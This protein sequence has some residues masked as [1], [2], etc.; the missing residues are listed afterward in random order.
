MSQDT[1]AIGSAILQLDRQLLKGGERIALGPRALAILSMLARHRGEIVSKDELFAEIWPDTTVEENALQ[2][3]VTA[4]RKALG[5]DADLL[6]TVRGIG[7]KLHLEAG[8]TA[9]RLRK[10]KLNRSQVERLQRSIRMRRSSPRRASP[11]VSS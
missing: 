1:I 9:P 2:V 5:E 6:E 10:P 11:V 4:V 7:Y 3:H 8:E